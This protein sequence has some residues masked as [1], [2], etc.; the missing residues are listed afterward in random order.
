MRDTPVDAATSVVALY[1][2][3]KDRLDPD[4]LA[5]FQS[6]LTAQ[7]GLQKPEL[8]AGPPSP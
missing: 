1:L 6:H 3:A 8:L 4:T 7:F 5:A 2:G